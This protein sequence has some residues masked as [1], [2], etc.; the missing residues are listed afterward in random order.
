MPVDK[1]ESLLEQ[2]CKIDDA[3]VTIGDL[4]NLWEY[5]HLQELK[6][7]LRTH[8]PYGT[9]VILEGKFALENFEELNTWL[10]LQLDIV[11]IRLT[12]LG[13]ENSDLE[14]HE[15]FIR[16]INRRY[17]NPTYHTI[18][19]FE[20]YKFHDN[21]RQIEVLQRW[22][23]LYG[24]RFSW[25]SFNNYCQQS[26]YTSNLPEYYPEQ[27]ACQKLNHQMHILPDGKVT[28]C[29]QDFLGKKLIGN[30]FDTT[31][32][33]NWNSSP[34]KALRQSNTPQACPTELCDKCHH[35]FY[36]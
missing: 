10:E 3:L 32:L 28:A 6:Q 26:G 35:G 20:L 5:S 8:K 19:N 13:Y 9:H 12:S 7:L 27:G 17:L 30:A 31:L 4:G 24:L 18:I 14:V 1:L 22:K 23:Q 29:R 15:N 21:W 36:V 25:N 33:E 11:T 2:I 16:E 34:L